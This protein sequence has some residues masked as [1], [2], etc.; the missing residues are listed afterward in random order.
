MRRYPL[1]YFPSYSHYR[2]EE[3]RSAEE[4]INSTELRFGQLTSKYASSSGEGEGGSLLAQLVKDR[5][6]LSWILGNQREFFNP[7]SAHTQNSRAVIA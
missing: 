6:M 3:E 7:H 1:P 5:V 2:P 4:A